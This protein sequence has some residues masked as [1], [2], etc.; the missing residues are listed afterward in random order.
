MYVLIRTPDDDDKSAV[1][2]Y[3]LFTLFYFP[4]ILIEVIEEN[5]E[6][7]FTVLLSMIVEISNLKSTRAYIQEV[8]SFK[9]F[10]V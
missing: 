4:T 7:L 10:H 1:N 6:S 2:K 8:Y 9:I 3:N 5:V